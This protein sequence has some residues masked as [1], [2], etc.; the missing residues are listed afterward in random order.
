MRKTSYRS[1]KW[2][3]VE[4]EPRAQCFHY[5]HFQYI[6]LVMDLLYVYFMPKIESE[7]ALFYCPSFVILNPECPNIRGTIFYEVATKVYRG[8]HERCSI[9]RQINKTIKVENKCMKHSIISARQVSVKCYSLKKEKTRWGNQ[10]KI[11]LYRSLSFSRRGQMLKS[12]QNLINTKGKEES[13][14]HWLLG[15]YSKKIGLQESQLKV[16]CWGTLSI[17]WEYSV[18]RALTKFLRY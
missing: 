16:T 15:K 5:R 17:Y 7:L 6:T 4:T 1:Y 8:T 18:K 12:H 11:L 14:W 13:T 3:V 9:K 2:Y 10:N